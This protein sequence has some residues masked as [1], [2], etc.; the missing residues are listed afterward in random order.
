MVLG[1]LSGRS[2]LMARQPI[3]DE[4]QGA[5]IKAY[6][7]Q[8]TIIGRQANCPALGGTGAA[9][10]DALISQIIDSPPLSQINIDFGRINR[11][12]SYLSSLMTSA[13]IIS[14]LKS[15]VENEMATVA[16]YMTNGASDTI[17]RLGAASDLGSMLNVQNQPKAFQTVV[18]LLG[19]I[20]GDTVSALE[21]FGGAY[22]N[23]DRNVDK[24]VTQ[25][26]GG[27]GYDTSSIYYANKRIIDQWRDT[28]VSTK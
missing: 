28:P 12:F 17:F 24:F 19:A 20:I 25:Q 16:Q 22:R 3:E 23:R 8:I 5:K 11:F 2:K 10:S 26:V 1:S 14:Q 9:N 21:H 15:K 7:D 6:Q 18:G 13:P 27:G 4:Q